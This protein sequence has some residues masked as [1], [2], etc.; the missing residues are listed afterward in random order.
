MALNPILPYIALALVVLYLVASPKAKA[1]LAHRKDEL[2]ANRKLADELRQLR[3]SES[4]ALG[5]LE[6][7]IAGLVK[8]CEA[9][10]V[11]IDRL[12]S[13]VDSFTGVVVASQSKD[14]EGPI[15]Q[16]DKQFFK[17]ELRLTPEEESA[18]A[19]QN[20]PL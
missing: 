8:V 19:Y 13:A 17:D 12:S 2:Q 6:G 20:F 1:F 11:Q 14:E 4:A 16:A 9:Q 10:V 18:Q 7:Y 3:E 5:K 15:E